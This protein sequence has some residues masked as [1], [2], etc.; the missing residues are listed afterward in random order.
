[1]ILGSGIDVIDVDRVER[2]L[3]RF[4]A[5]FEERVFSPHEIEAC[6]RRRHPALHY[7]LRFAAKEAVMK[8]L[9]TG[10]ARGVRWVDIETREPAAGG[11]WGLT[12]RGPAAVHAAGGRFHLALSRTR[13]LALAAVLLERAR[14]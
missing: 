9:G 10:W 3:A 6:R 2:A 12:L 8:A 11:A 5:R 13:R 7:A 14:S 4:G 1:M